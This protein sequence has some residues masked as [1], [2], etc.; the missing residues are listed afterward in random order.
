M[1]DTKYSSTIKRAYPAGV[2]LQEGKT[3]DIGTIKQDTAWKETGS[4]TGDRECPKQ[5]FREFAS[6]TTGDQ[7]IDLSAV[8]D[9]FGGTIDFDNLRYLAITNRATNAAHILT[10]GAAAA[11]PFFDAT[12]SVL[13]DATDVKVIQPGA[14]LILVN[15]PLGPG[16]SVGTKVN[17]KLAF[18]ANAFGAAV[19]IKGY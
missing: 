15:K 18:G 3:I 13:E 16:V 4:G 12:G 14:T 11:N 2:A 6:S 19:D 1:S 5:A 10:V 7:A 9:G 8:S 17:L